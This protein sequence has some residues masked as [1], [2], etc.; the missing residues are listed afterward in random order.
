MTTQ[1]IYNLLIQAGI[2]ADP[3]GR[4]AIEEKLAKVREEYHDLPDDKKADFDT[5][6]L[7]NPYSDSG[8]HFGDPNKQVKRVLVGIDIDP[9]E[10]L[11]TKELERMGKPVDLIIGHHPIGKSLALLHE[12]MDIQTDVLARAGVPE[13]I[14]EG[15]LRERLSQV[16]RS[17]A[18]SNHYQPVD[19]AKILDV[20]IMNFHTPG[21]NSVW[22]FIDEFL[23][24]KKPKTVGEIVE[25]LKEIPEYHEA[26]KL[27]AGPTI[28]AGDEKARA[29]KIVVSGMTG[30]TGSSEKIYERMSHYGIGT[31]IA[32]HISEKNREEAS[33]H[34]INVVVAGHISSDSLGINLLLDKL[35]KAGIEIIPCSGLIRVSRNKKR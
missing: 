8:F 19:M 11:L 34:Y 15:T 14:A 18:S 12:V 31:E 6:K 29:G 23:A 16:S 3:R 7:T 27:Q 2:D 9:A 35:E 20:P 30:G 33:K 26:T 5:D 10:V 32:M 22:R 21:D 24:K 17:V 1:E 28:F 4:Q 25:I 13:N